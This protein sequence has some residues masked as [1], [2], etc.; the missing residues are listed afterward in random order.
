MKQTL[1]KAVFET[2]GEKEALLLICVERFLLRNLQKFFCKKQTEN[3]VTI[4]HFFNN[5]IQL[6]NS[7]LLFFY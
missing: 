5:K 3:P 4:P 2:Y 6:K 1:V 7:R